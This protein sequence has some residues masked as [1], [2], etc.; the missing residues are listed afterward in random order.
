[1]IRKKVLEQIKKQF[2]QGIFEHLERIIQV[3]DEK[4]IPVVLTHEEKSNFNIDFIDH[5]VFLV[6]NSNNFGEFIE[7][8]Y[9]DYNEAVFA[10]DMESV[11]LEEGENVI[12]YRAI[13]TGGNIFFGCEYTNKK[14]LRFKKHGNIPFLIDGQDPHEAPK[15]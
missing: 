13:I 4:K 12:L 7:R 1:M 15:A 2:D 6:L 9:L 14:L 3:S 5:P 8:E 10:F 11:M